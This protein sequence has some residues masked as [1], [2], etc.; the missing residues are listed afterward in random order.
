MKNDQGY[1]RR[2]ARRKFLQ[3]CAMSAWAGV[4]GAGAQT[5]PQPLTVIYPNLDGVGEQN[6]GYQVLKLILPK[7]GWAYTLELHP[8]AANGSRARAMLKAGEISL[9]D[10]GANP[11][12][13]SEHAPVYFP[14]DRGLLGYRLCLIHRDN[15]SRFA[16]IEHLND[17]RRFT[18]GQ[19][20]RWPD[21][22]ILRAAGI[23]VETGPTLEALFSMLEAK[24][25][26]F[27]PLGVGEI[28][29]FLG[30][31]ASKAPS[32]QIDTR[33]LLTYRFG[34][35]F[36]VDPANTQLHQAIRVGLERAFA[37]NSLQKLLDAPPFSV[38]NML[39]RDNLQQRTR[40]ALDNPLMTDSF[41]AIPE[42]YFL[43][44]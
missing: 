25:F 39:K 2:W 16:A 15:A 37:D 19:G 9:V 40:I 41:R 4:S 18:A 27:L 7:S 44:L 17:L 22:A 8:A 29:S 13:E 10:L 42:K 35:L 32:V 34:R 12:F 30:Q 43:R 6:L 5:S 23:A 24:R 36:Y 26:D 28:H 1:W 33:V 11:D 38:A 14:I 20:A 3:H 31:F 21:G